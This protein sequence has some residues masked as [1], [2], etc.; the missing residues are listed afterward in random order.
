LRTERKRLAIVV[1]LFPLIAAAIVVFL[2]GGGGDGAGAYALRLYDRSIARKALV[3]RIRFYL[4]RVKSG[5]TEVMANP[6]VPPP[7]A[8]QRNFDRLLD[9]VVS[10]DPVFRPHVKETLNQM[11]ATCEGCLDYLTSD[12]RHNAAVQCRTRVAH[13]GAN[14][15]QAIDQ[16]VRILR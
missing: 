12:D 6:L 2:G 1:G 8:L 3:P 16:I 13:D 14:A 9:A 15:I 7:S 10:G 5:L 11:L 4:D